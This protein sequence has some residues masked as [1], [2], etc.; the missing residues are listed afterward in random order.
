MIEILLSCM[1]YDASEVNKTGAACFAHACDSQPLRWVYPAGS[2]RFIRRG[3][4]PRYAVSAFAVFVRWRKERPQ[5]VCG[6]PF[7]GFVGVSVCVERFVCFVPAHIPGRFRVGAAISGHYRDVRVAQLME[8]E[9]AGNRVDQS[10]SLI[11]FC[12][13]LL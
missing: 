3:D 12:I 10:L 7:R 1:D 11:P 6:F 13:R 8:V 5:L 4:G 2:Y 9:V